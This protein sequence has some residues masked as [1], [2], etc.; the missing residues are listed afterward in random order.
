MKH[1]MGKIAGIIIVTVLLTGCATYY[2]KNLKFQQ[3][4]YAGNFEKADKILESDK[5]APK[6]K[7]QL[8]YD[9]NRGYTNWMLQKNELSNQ[10]FQQADR[11][12]EDQQK[13]YGMEALALVTNP[14]MKP[15]KPED[16]ESVM[17]HYFTTL[18]YI[19][20]GKMEDAMV[21]CRR[22][23][24]VLN[25]LNDKYPSNKNRYKRD[26]FA[27]TLMGLI[28]D[29]NRDYNNAFIAYRNALEIYET[30]YAKNFKITTPNQL[31]LDLLRTAY[32]SGF[33]QELR[34][35]EE[36]FKLSYDRTRKPEASLVFF[37][38]NGFGPVKD[39]WSINFTKLPG[40][41]PG[42]VTL[43]NDE[44]GMSFPIFIG[45]YNAN[46]RAAFSQM[47]MMRI[48]FPK[49]IE[50]VPYYSQASVEMNGQTWSLDEAQNI[51]DIAFKTLHD[52]MVREMATSIARL[53]AKKALEALA[54][55]Q[56]QNLG[57]IISIANALTEKADTRNWQTLPYAISYTRVPL[58]VGENNVS[59]N[60][61]GANGTRSYQ[62]KFDARKNETVFHSF[63]N[64]E[65]VPFVL[66][67][68]Y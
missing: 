29:A 44:L 2:Q 43:A 32:L 57:A 10:F 52:R 18:N 15:Y 47:S 58:N 64:I 55:R 63:H 14:M 50:R 5:K 16:F 25:K 9:L 22:I 51:N 68:Q 41:G 54:D 12:I 40:S 20:L 31:K 38:M 33:D 62:F 46:E 23:E 7:N 67:G 26:A 65:I 34:Q 37:W 59:L 11:Y 3:N 36:K 24:L 35:Y 28:Y 21:E 42:W 49:Y 1:C 8:L 6:G 60:V 61:K 66:R 30:D 39:E 45:N 56:N 27:Q 4:V 17:L 53:A 19:Q 48:A 13:N